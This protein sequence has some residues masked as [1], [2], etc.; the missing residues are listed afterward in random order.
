MY[1][2]IYIY[3]INIIHGNTQCNLLLLIIYMHLTCIYVCCCLDRVKIGL[4]SSKNICVICFIESPLKMIKNAFHFN[5]KAL[6]VLKIV[7]F[8]L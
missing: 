4:S 3:I 1:I 8:L 7:K 6:F 2:Y 5:L